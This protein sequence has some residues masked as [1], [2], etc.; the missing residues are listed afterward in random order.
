MG[1]IR[2]KRTTKAGNIYKH[3]YRFWNDGKLYQHI[4]YD[5]EWAAREVR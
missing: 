3:G 5:D 2:K 4:G 1:Y